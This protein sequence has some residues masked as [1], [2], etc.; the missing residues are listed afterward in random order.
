MITQLTKEQ[1]AFFPEFIE[2][3]T[4]IGLSCDPC[5]IEKSTNAINKC[6]EIAG[7]PAPKQII[8]ADS[9]VSAGIIYKIIKQDSVRN[10][11][12]NS[13]GDSVLNSVR[14]S[15]RNSVWNSVRNS[16]GNS[17]RDSVLNS[18][19]NSVGDSVW[20]SIYGPH[21][22]SW[23]SY[24][25]YMRDVL[26]LRHQTE[27]ITGLIDLASHC[28]WCIPLTETAIIQNRHSELHLDDQ[29]RLHSESGYA[30]KYPDGWGFHSWHGV[31]VPARVIED[32]KSITVSDIQSE[33]NVEIRRI[34]R[35]QYG[36]GRYLKDTGAKLIHADYEGA[37]KGSAPRALLID[38]EGQRWLVG[39]DGSTGRI[40]YMRVPDDAVTCSDAHSA[41]CGFDEKRILCKS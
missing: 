14:N 29:G 30:I 37:R 32:P 6:Y 11:V 3:W 2:K 39:T 31:T 24:Y 26:G 33:T 13:V 20:D 8:L 27:K 22:A 16:V 34:M 40:Y 38:D 10:S 35:T 1:E 5:D 25:S 9:P 12:R 36:D 41:I 18:V 19:G 21:D 4:K 17:V 7:L 15:V 23:L 28:G